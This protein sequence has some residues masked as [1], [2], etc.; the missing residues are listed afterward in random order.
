MKQH[1]KILILVS[2]LSFLLAGCGSTSQQHSQ[3]KNTKTEQKIKEHSVS[4]DSSTISDHSATKNNN[5]SLLSSSAITSSNSKISSSIKSSITGNHS[6][7]ILTTEQFNDEVWANIKQT[8][9]VSDNQRQNYSFENTTQNGFATVTVRENHDSNQNADPTSAP[10][11]GTYR[12]DQNG[13]LQR[14]DVVTDSWQTIS[15]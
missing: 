10:V 13:Q 11:V 1:H 14:F 12:I 7:Q 9:H 3:Q 15:H 8:Q 4:R 2:L 6:N 5:E